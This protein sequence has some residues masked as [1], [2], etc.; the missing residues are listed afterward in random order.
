MHTQQRH[1]NTDVHLRTRTTVK[2]NTS[3][4]FAYP[5]TFVRKQP[6]ISLVDFWR[7]AEIQLPCR[8]D[9]ND[10]SWVLT[11]RTACN[12]AVISAA[13]TEMEKVSQHNRRRRVSPNLIEIYATAAGDPSA[14]T[15][16]FGTV[17][18]THRRAPT[19]SIIWKGYA[20]YVSPLPHTVTGHAVINAVWL[21]ALHI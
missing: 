4:T 12:A 16:D 14:E 19:A 6:L 11:P 21:T 5:Y 3:R 8:T 13:I 9:G 1:M 17:I 7:P 20:M 15:A 10:R 2:P 18:P